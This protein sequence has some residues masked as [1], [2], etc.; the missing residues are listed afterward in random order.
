KPE[1]R[2]KTFDGR[3]RRARKVIVLG[4]IRGPRRF[5]A[6]PDTSRQTDSRSEGAFTTHCLEL[7]KTGAT[8]LPD[9]QTAQELTLRPRR[10]EISYFPSQGFTNGLENSRHRIA[11]G[12]RFGEDFRDGKIDRPTV[13]GALPLGNVDDGSEPSDHIAFRVPIRS[14]NRMQARDSD[15]AKRYFRFVFGVLAFK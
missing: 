1:R 14:I 7:W 8:A 10:P 4:N 15:A 6:A 3:D 2:M 11:K 13:F 9:F 12:G 5:Q